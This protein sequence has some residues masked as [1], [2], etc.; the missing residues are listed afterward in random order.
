MVN[1]FGKGS[2]LRAQKKRF[3]LKVRWYERFQRKQRAFEKK[4]WRFKQERQK[5]GDKNEL[6]AKKIPEKRRLGFR[7]GVKG[8][9]VETCGPEP[10]MRSG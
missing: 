2:G 10:R 6:V 7:R 9:K 5:K 3:L 1:W 4:I 8:K